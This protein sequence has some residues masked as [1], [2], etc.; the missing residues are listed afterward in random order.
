[1]AQINLKTHYT[2]QELA[3]MTLPGMPVTRPGIM[4]RAKTCGWQM[5]SR[6]GRGGGNEYAVESLPVEAQS[7]IREKAYRSILE[8]GAGVT[9]KSNTTVKHKVKPTREVELMRQCPA[10]LEREVSSLTEKQKQIADARAALA[11][12]VERL[13]DAGMSRTAA[14]KF[15]AES[16]RNSTLPEHLRSLAEIANARKGSTRS[17]VGERSLQE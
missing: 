16:S 1:M 4:A 12:E 15:I 8:T 11:M 14:V 10:L 9:E 13:R 5:R 2:A 17:G 7:A 6:V 3:D